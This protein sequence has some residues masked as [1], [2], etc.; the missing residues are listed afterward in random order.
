M[1]AIETE[2]NGILFRSRLEARWA[3]FFD[4]CNLNWIYEPEC[5]ILSNTQKYTPDFY[6]K[7]F[8]LYIEVKPNFDWLENKYHFD[9]YKLFG[10]EKGLLVLSSSYPDLQTNALFEKN[11]NLK[12]YQG[13]LNVVFVPN[14]KY[15]P[16]FYT[17]CEIGSY[18]NL[19]LEDFEKE[20]NLVKQYR[21]YK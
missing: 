8:D 1:T 3:I 13:F 11:N 19:F 17:G 16:L 5:F 2:Y 6:I 21:F 14:H 18:E 4:A 15:S 10:Y 12:L 9:R 7:D 20:I